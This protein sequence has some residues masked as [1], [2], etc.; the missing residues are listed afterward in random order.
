MPDP[1]PEQLL[2]RLT[3]IEAQYTLLHAIEYLMRI[4]TLLPPPYGMSGKASGSCP[5][6]CIGPARPSVF[7]L[8][9]LVG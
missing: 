4:E 2:E 6:S 8:T 9:P 3:R 1:L 5:I 7:A